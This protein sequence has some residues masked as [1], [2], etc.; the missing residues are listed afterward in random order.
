MILSGLHNGNDHHWLKCDNF[1][2]NELIGLN[3]SITCKISLTGNIINWSAP[4]RMNLHCHVNNVYYYHI[5][6]VMMCLINKKLFDLLSLLAGCP[7]DGPLPHCP[8]LF[9]PNVNTSPLLVIT[10]AWALPRATCVT[11][12]PFRSVTSPNSYWEI[13][14]VTILDLWE[15]PRKGEIVVSVFTI[16]NPNI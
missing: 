11:W 5:I 8:L 6:Q 12:W 14:D 15:F 1:V 10:L 3:L 7:G 16:I 2:N 13:Q 9:T 4:L